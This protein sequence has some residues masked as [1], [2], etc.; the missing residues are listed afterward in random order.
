MGGWDWCKDCGGEMVSCECPEED[1]VDENYSHEEYMC[2]DISDSQ[3]V[4]TLG[5]NLV[6]RVEVI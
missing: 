4:W 1:Y 5:D 2:E 3:V 6:W